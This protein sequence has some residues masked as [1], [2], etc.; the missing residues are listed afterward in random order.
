MFD[1][2][3]SLRCTE[4]ISGLVGDCWSNKAS[5]LKESRISNY[6]SCCCL[7]GVLMKVSSGALII[8][9]QL[10]DDVYANVIRKRQIGQRPR[11]EPWCIF[12]LRV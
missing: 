10:N 1:I 7:V 12:M 9:K 8:D 3:C 5:E 6:E 11:A 4:L 2:K